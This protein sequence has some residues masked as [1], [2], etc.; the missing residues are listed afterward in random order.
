[1]PKDQQTAPE[2]DWPR[3]VAKRS[4]PRIRRKRVMFTEVLNHQQ[5]IS[6]PPADESAQKQAKPSKRRQTPA[7]VAGRQLGD[8]RRL[9]VRT[10]VDADDEGFV[11][12]VATILWFYEGQ[13]FSVHGKL[14]TR[15]A[16]SVEAVSY[17]L[18]GVAFYPARITE[19]IALADAARLAPSPETIG[20][21]IGLTPENRTLHRVTQIEAPSEPRPQREAR[22]GA[23][24]RERDRLRR[25]VKRA[26][27]QSD[28]MKL[29][30]ERE[31]ARIAAAKRREKERA[32][33]A[34]A[35]R[36]AINTLRREAIDKRHERKAAAME[37]KKETKRARDRA[38]REYNGVTPRSESLS[39]T[40]PWLAEGVSR[41]TWY[42]KNRRNST[43][44]GE[45]ETVPMA[46]TR[47]PKERHLAQARAPK[48]RHLAQLVFVP[49][50]VETPANQ[51]VSKDCPTGRVGNSRQSR[52]YI[53]AAATDAASVS[54]SEAALIAAHG[55]WIVFPRVDGSPPLVV[56]EDS[57][58]GL[59]GA[60]DEIGRNATAR[61]VVVAGEGQGLA[62]S[63]D[64]GERDGTGSAAAMAI[65]DTASGV[66]SPDECAAQLAPSTSRKA[67]F[68]AAV[69]S[70]SALEAR[71]REAPV[72]GAMIFAGRERRAIATARRRAMARR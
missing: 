60:V 35:K 7:A 10:I 42:R 48:E 20:R 31:A 40:K 66:T 13:K 2:M 44:E 39:A 3:S 5:A 28:P 6:S 25:A 52:R 4:G 15:R 12:A 17:Y 16:P 38:W 19:I 30:L 33:W 36:A 45:R 23:E 41:R 9:W 63:E 50:E 18:P 46:Q 49:T 56:D 55:P 65:G 58:E 64:V 22:K 26:D 68:L 21:M 59:G 67:F 32:E 70:A 61:A 34:P 62:E 72:V 69:T 14:R 11:W 37:T 27:R 71:R 1:M 54:P 8:I 24:K 51:G 57:D 43:S 47:V 53:Y 29:Y